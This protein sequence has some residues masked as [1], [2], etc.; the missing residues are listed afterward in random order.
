M[1]KLTGIANKID[2]RQLEKIVSEKFKPKKE[3]IEQGRLKT[4]RLTSIPEEFSSALIGI[5]GYLDVFRTGYGRRKIG[6]GMGNHGAVIF[7]NKEDH[8]LY[9]YFNQLLMEAKL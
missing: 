4:L 5:T 6:V 3:V 2:L 1:V 8:K 7:S 9:Q